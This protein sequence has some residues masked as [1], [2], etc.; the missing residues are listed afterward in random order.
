MESRERKIYNLP[1]SL[2]ANR[3]KRSSTSAYSSGS[4]ELQCHVRPMSHQEKGL[5]WH[6]DRK[7]GQ[8]H[9]LPPPVQQCSTSPVVQLDPCEYSAVP[10]TEAPG[11]K[12]VSDSGEVPTGVTVLNSN[13]ENIRVQDGDVTSSLANAVI[14]QD[15][16]EYNTV[17]VL[18]LAAP[19]SVSDSVEIPTGVLNSNPENITVQDD[20][21]TSCL[22]NAVTPV[23]HQDPCEYST[24]TW[25]GC[26]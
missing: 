12:A 25:S 16:C 5:K 11:S 4:S 24:S 15:P 18:R 6:Q 19:E 9:R 8:R 26:F 7:K 17:P 22:V 13:S 23:I 1:M 2:A 10:V 3:E 14:R 21:F 20:D